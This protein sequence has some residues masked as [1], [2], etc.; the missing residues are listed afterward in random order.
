MMNTDDWGHWIS[1]LAPGDSVRLLEETEDRD[2]IPGRLG[3]IVGGNFLVAAV[4]LEGEKEHI[5]VPTIHL[6]RPNPLQE[7]ARAAE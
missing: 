3:E 7:L 4:R 5:E 1:Q 6:I 2:L